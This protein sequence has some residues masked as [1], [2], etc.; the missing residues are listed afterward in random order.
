[1]AVTIN[2]GGTRHERVFIGTNWRKPFKL[3]DYDTDPSGLT[4]KDMDGMALTLDMRLQRDTAAVVFTK[5]IGSGL[6]IV[7][8]FNPVLADSTQ[9]LILDV[10]DTDITVAKVGALGGKFPWSLKRT[11]AGGKTILAE[12]VID[13]ERAT[14]D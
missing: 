4:A 14:Q 7:G 6:S 10:S 1:M 8:T 9:E 12:G 2:I 3:A 13:V 11:T 5:S